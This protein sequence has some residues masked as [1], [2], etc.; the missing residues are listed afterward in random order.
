MDVMEFLPSSGGLGQEFPAPWR[1]EEDSFIVILVKS[2][3]RVYSVVP[4]LL[5]PRGQWVELK[6]LPL[7]SLGLSDDQPPP[8]AC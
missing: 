4:T 1:D 5:L 2:C 6:F 3:Y 8:E 7:Y